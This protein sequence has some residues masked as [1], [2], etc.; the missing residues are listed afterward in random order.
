MLKQYRASSAALSL[1]PRR[2]SR[3]PLRSHHRQANQQE[4]IMPNLPCRLLAIA[5]LAS[6][7]L[8]AP[9]AYAFNPQPDPPAKGKAVISDKSIKGGQ[10]TT[11]NLG[12]A[13]SKIKGQK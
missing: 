13:T 8:A 9:S 4:D 3:A 10:V 6:I 1:R 2:P 11:P 12:N 5:T 7:G